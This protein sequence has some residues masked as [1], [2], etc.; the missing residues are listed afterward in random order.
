[1][2]HENDLISH[3]EFVEGNQTTRKI[4][5]LSQQRPSIG[6]RISGEAENTC[7]RSV[8]PMESH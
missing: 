5:S 4:L 8:K 7:I 6:L 1:M 2:I 3:S